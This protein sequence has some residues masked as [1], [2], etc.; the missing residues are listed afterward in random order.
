MTRKKKFIFKK[1]I[2]NDG[3]D[4]KPEKRNTKNVAKN[5]CKAFISYLDDKN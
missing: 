5:F 3:I 4:H 1:K 2:I